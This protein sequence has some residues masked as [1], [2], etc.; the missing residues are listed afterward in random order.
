MIFIS[1]YDEVLDVSP[2]TNYNTENIMALII[3]AIN[4]NGYIFVLAGID[5]M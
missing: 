5:S 1:L 2:I 3:E 4:N